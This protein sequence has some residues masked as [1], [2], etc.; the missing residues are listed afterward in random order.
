[1]FLA[2]FG[3]EVVKVDPP[4]SA[5][6]RLGDDE[7]FAAYFAADRN[8][9]SIIIDL[10]KQEGRDVLYRLVQDADVLVECFRPGVTERL[11]IDYT[12][13]RNLNER[14]VYCSLTGF[15]KDGPYSNMI[16]HDMN[17]CA[18]AGALSLIGPRDGTPCLPSNFLA[19]MAGAGLHAVAGILIALLARSNT[20]RGQLVDISY[21]DGVISLMIY[22]TIN[23]FMNGRVPK[24]GETAL[25]GG[26]PWAQVFKC[27][28]NEYF[29]IGCAELRFWK[30][31][32]L[33]VGREDLI[34]FHT[35]CGKEADE[36]VSE[37]AE[38]FKGK[39]RDEWFEFF[40]DKEIPAGPVYY[41]NETFSNQ[42]VLH[43]KMVTEIDHP[44]Y[45]KI[46]QTGIPIKLS[47][48]PGEIK[49]VGVKTGS[50]SLEILQKLGYQNEEIARFLDL[51]IIV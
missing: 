7:K 30:N 17:I 49:H 39:R 42:H 22:Q 21:L 29:T 51:G 43:R 5:F 46:R 24:R 48:T 40:R 6:E 14:L 37:L 10:K 1:M 47:D 4:V 2:D 45:G 26:A 19:D 11:K 41:V 50:N 9:K 8:K 13:L 12:T 28:D 18:I 33:A 34:R 15:G 20:G 27:K 16:G 3:A 23:Y 36:V 31:L 38:I 35:A 44:Q 32:C 25:T